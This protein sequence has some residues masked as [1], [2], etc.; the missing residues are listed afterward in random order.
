MIRSRVPAGEVFLVSV[1]ASE[2]VTLQMRY[3]GQTQVLETQ[4]S[5]SA[6]TALPG[7]HLFATEA[8]D[9]AGN[10]AEASA[11]VDALWAPQWTL[12]APEQ[13]RAGDPLAAWVLF[14]PPPYGSEAAAVAR[15]HVTL[16]DEPLNLVPR[17]E[18]WVAL[19][20]IPLAAEAGNITL[21]ATVE[22]EFGRSWQQQRTLAI[23]TDLGPIDLV[24]LGPATRAL[25]TDDARILEAIAYDEALAL[26]PR[27]PR[28]M[29]AF[30]LPLEGRETAA[31]GERRRYAAGGNISYHL[32]V[33]IAAP[34]GTPVLAT[35]DGVVRVAGFYPIKG[36][37]VVVDHGQGLTSHH[38][39]LAN[40]DVKVG[41]AIMRGEV[42]GG[43]GS[44]GVSTGPHL[45]WEMR[46]DGMPTDPLAWVGAHYPVVQR[47]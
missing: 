33:D 34:V 31:F 6:W 1:N 47:R 3:A 43:V 20:G 44:T 40:I 15:I 19:T 7:R 5:V 27:E 11:W 21:Q 12:T 2:P 17:P 18:G 46:V 24:P 26:V 38:F 10:R 8:S 4:A 13:L 41:D 45:H 36:G 37:W 25:L 42:I 16:A 39:H 28:W 9:A 32:G 14:T 23:N 22:D 30:I 35:N 29:E